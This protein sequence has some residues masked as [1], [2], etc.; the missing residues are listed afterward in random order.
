MAKRIDFNMQRGVAANVS[1]GL[2]RRIAAVTRAAAAAFAKDFKSWNDDRLTNAALERLND[3][4]LRD[5]GLDRLEVDQFFVAGTDNHSSRQ[6]IYVQRE[7]AGTGFVG[8]P[9]A[10]F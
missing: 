4:Y 6:S 8:F 2:S 5:I 10:K 9:I 7:A 1:S 3:H